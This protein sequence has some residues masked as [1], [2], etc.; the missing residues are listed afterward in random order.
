MTKSKMVMCNN[1]TQWFCYNPENPWG[2]EVKRRGYS[3]RYYCGEC[4]AACK[5]TS[6]A[7]IREYE[8]K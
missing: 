2:I 7:R 1:C 8:H 3:S 6:K 4:I 5:I